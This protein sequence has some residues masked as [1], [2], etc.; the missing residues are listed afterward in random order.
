MKCPFCESETD[1]PLMFDNHARFG[2]GGVQIAQRDQVIEELGWQAA[3]Q[4]ARAVEL[5]AALREVLETKPGLAFDVAIAKA[6][7]LLRDK[8]A[9]PNRRRR[10]VESIHIG[11]KSR[12]ADDWAYYYE[13]RRDEETVVLIIPDDE[14]LAAKVAHAI[15]QE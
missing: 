13:I 4:H 14:G 11:S 1:R 12:Y 7:N 5:E 15:S 6:R 3:E 2:H 9:A 8:K 10:K